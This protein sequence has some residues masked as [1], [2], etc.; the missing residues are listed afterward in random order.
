MITQVDIKSEC[1]VSK[2]D[3]EIHK[4]ELAGAFQRVKRFAVLDSVSVSV[5]A[6][7]WKK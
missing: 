7:F 2:E 6:S 3:T 1:K 4:E 5:V